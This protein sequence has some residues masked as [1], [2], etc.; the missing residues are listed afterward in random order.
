ME[1]FWKYIGV[2]LFVDQSCK[3][4]RK[5]FELLDLVNGNFSISPLTKFYGFIKNDEATVSKSE[6]L[7]TLPFK[8]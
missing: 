1:K 7:A 6:Y 4:Y 3:I 2:T 8:S 5:W